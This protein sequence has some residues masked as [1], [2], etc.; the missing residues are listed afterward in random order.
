MTMHISITNSASLD[1]FARRVAPHTSMSVSRFKSVIAKAFDYGHIKAL[2]AAL[3][4]TPAATEKATQQSSNELSSSDSYIVEQLILWLEDNVCQG[5]EIAFDNDDEVF[6]EQALSALNN[7][8]ALKT[9]STCGANV[10]SETLRFKNLLDSYDAEAGCLNSLGL[11][12]EDE[13][14]SEHWGQMEDSAEKLL[15][16]LAAEPELAKAIA[17]L[18]ATQLG[19]ISKYLFAFSEMSKNMEYLKDKI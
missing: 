16:D 8:I 13:L 7:L 4:A 19:S 15:S 12:S 6:S 5:T 2:E 11:D 10:A 9:V 14:E 3:N 18:N 1:A 17:I